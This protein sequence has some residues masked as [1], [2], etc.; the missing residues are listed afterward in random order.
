MAGKSTT[1]APAKAPAKS[2]EK[3]APAAAPAAAEKL[4]NQPA[5]PSPNPAP[6]AVTPPASTEQPTSEAPGL[7]AGSSGQDAHPDTAPTAPDAAAATSSPA[8]A[9]PE[10]PVG[11]AA[12][13]GTAT[14]TVNDLDLD[15]GEVEGLWITAIPEQGFRRCGWRFTREGFGIAL[16]ALTVEQ[17]EILENEP[18]LKVERGIFSGRVGERLE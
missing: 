6:T 7:D 2:A 15:D 10:A 13:T 9:A 5:A 1:K 17:I 18:N 11:G 4:D 3:A 12:A 8:P 16:D 14:D